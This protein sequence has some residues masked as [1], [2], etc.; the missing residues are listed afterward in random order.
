[1]TKQGKI[2][3]CL[4]EVLPSTRRPG[5]SSDTWGQGDAPLGFVGFVAKGHAR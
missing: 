3:P 5:R 4:Q 1:M 2:Y